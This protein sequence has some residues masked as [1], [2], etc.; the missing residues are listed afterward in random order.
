MAHR[1][2][3]TSWD[4]LEDLASQ[5]K[6]SRPFAVKAPDAALDEEKQWQLKQAIDRS[7]ARERARG[8]LFAQRSVNDRLRSG[9]H[10]EL[11]HQ[12]Y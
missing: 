10:R 2:G 11:M 12:H 4:E 7:R 9:E 1:A 3:T 6:I 8:V 5:T